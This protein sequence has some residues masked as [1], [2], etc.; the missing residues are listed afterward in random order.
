MIRI[1][2]CENFAKLTYARKDSFYAGESTPWMTVYI[3]DKDT[4]Q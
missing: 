4:T 3:V 2:W 1:H